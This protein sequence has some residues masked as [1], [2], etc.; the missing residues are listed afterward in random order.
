M[1]VP[2]FR[3]QTSASFCRLPGINVCTVAGVSDIS[4]HEQRRRVTGQQPTLPAQPAESLD[5]PWPGGRPMLAPVNR[6]AQAL[7]P[8]IGPVALHRTGV[9][10]PEDLG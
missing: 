10:A 7:R 5:Q 9:P 1:A 8:D 2:S 6:L 3:T 4:C